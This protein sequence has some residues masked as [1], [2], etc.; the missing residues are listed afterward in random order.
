MGFVSAPPHPVDLITCH[1]DS[2]NYLLSTRDLALA[3]CRFRANLTPGGHAIFDMV[4]DFSQEPQLG[5][6]I[7]RFKMPGVHSIWV[8]AW[9]P[10]RRL[11]VVTMH[12]RFATDD[13]KYRHEREVHAQRQYPV[14]MV[15]KLLVR[16]GF[17]VR[18][19]H[20]AFSLKSATPRTY[21]AV[22]VVRKV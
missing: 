15:V 5:G 12:N 1:F 20:D 4:T 19:V 6:R 8:I 7:Q 3:F 17:K 21:R 22:Y 9:E 13:W 10:A 14:G 2:L 18:G 16:C 11:R